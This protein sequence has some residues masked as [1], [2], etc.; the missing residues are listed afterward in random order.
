MF[1]TKALKIVGME[2]VGKALD[3]FLIPTAMTRILGRGERGGLASF[4]AIDLRNGRP[5]SCTGYWEAS[6]GRM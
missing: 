5:L 3:W 6:D 1:L 4:I 2:L